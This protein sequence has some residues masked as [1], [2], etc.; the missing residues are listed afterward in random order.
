VKLRLEAPTGRDIPS[1]ELGRVLG[2]VGAGNWGGE[3]ELDLSE[4]GLPPVR[5][6]ESLMFEFREE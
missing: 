2:G 3:C 4:E 6:D 5:L 1:S